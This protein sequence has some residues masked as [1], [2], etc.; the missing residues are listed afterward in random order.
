M[1]LIFSEWETEARWLSKILVWCLEQRDTSSDDIVAAGAHQDLEE[2]WWT[3]IYLLFI[4]YH[5]AIW[6]MKENTV[7][8]GVF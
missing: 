6:E 5:S 7:M 8:V 4:I 2:D 1:Y 3:F